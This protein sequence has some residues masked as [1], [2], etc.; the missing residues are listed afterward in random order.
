MEEGLGLLR[1]LS[2]AAALEGLV[3]ATR[4]LPPG[5]LGAADYRVPAFE[6]FADWDIACHYAPFD[7]FEPAARVALVGINP[8]TAQASAAFAAARDALWAGTSWAE[9][10]RRAKRTAAFS[11]PMLTNLARMLDAIELP[12]RLTEAGAPEVSRARA[13]FGTDRTEVH[14]T[15]CVRYPVAVNGRDYT[16]RRPLLARSPQM[17][18]FVREVLEPEL[19]S[20]PNAIV[21]PLGRIAGEAVSTLV[22]AGR[23]DGERVLLGLPH[24]SGTNGHREQD[25]ERVREELRQG[26]RR[27]F[28]R[29]PAAAAG[30]RMPLPPA[31]LESV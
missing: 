11:G 20:V 6:L 22:E 23:L 15:Y 24:P 25:F 27:W 18:A 16:G 10:L 9:A 29:R 13:L 26:L 1:R 21:I 8:G 14:C 2:S 5:R 17:L 12:R 3:A 28:G 30:A 19:A 4:A 31:S 7:H